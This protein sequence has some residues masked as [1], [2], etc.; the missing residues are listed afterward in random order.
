MLS[1]FSRIG[2]GLN[3]VCSAATTILRVIIEKPFFFYIYLTRALVLLISKASSNC[4]IVQLYNTMLFIFSL[5]KLTHSLSC[6][7]SSQ[8]IALMVPINGQNEILTTKKIASTESISV[9]RGL[10]MVPALYYIESLEIFFAQ[11]RDN[12]QCMEISVSW[13]GLL[14][15]FP[16]KN[17]QLSHPKV[18]IR[19]FFFPIYTSSKIIPLLKPILS[20]W[21]NLE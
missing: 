12:G 15:D 11:V 20:Y 1:V 5:L 10:F 19:L 16:D 18:G 3:T 9:G 4:D 17:R 14:G 2:T 21:L 6:L 13:P 8:L 7:F